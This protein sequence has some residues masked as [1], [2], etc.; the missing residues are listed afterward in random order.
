MFLTHELETKHLL[1]PPVTR[2]SFLK[3]GA[4]LTTGLAS[5][6]LSARAHVN[7]NSKLRI[8]QI[9]VGGIGELQRNGLNGHPGVEWAGLCGVD[10]RELDKIKK[11]FPSAWTV[12]DF[13]EGFAPSQ[14]S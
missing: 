2:R 8:F 3:T 7:Q 13:R 14:V 12:K 11:Q 6:G 9:G 4:V 1:R 10:Q 5:L